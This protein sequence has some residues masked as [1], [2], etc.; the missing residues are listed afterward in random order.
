M[1]IVD[2]LLLTLDDVVSERIS[3]RKAA[4]PP[5][6]NSKRVLKVRAAL[7]AELNAKDVVDG[8]TRRLLLAIRAYLTTNEVP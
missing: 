4:L 8:N 6:G 7:N 1:A 3:L 2:G 5:L